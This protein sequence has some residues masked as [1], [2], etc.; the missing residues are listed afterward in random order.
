MK[1]YVIEIISSLKNEYEEDKLEVTTMGNFTK[2]QDDYKISYNENSEGGM[3]GKTSLTVH[4]N[5]QITLVRTGGM[6]TRLILEKGQRH[7]CHYDTGYG[8]MMVGVFTDRI[9]S[10]L[11]ETGG[12]LKFNYSVDINS[13]FSSNNEI[14]IKVKEAQHV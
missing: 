1:E 12:E 2:H 4:G 3:T 10:S 6:A 13:E 9:D 7:L 11:S 5:R 14:S 8:E